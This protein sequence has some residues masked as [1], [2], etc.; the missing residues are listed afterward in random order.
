MLLLQRWQL[1]VWEGAGLHHTTPVVSWTRSLHGYGKIFLF[2]PLVK[3]DN[4]TRHT[5]MA[6]ECAGV[7]WITPHNLCSIVN[8]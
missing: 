2:I 7:S 6:I 1:N 4:A 3:I 8:L 5:E